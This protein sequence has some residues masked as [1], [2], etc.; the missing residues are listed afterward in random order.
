MI[1][2]II[3]R[4]SLINPKLFSSLTREDDF[5]SV[6]IKFSE[7]LIF[8]YSSEEDKKR[9]RTLNQV[10]SKKGE[11]NRKKVINGY[12]IE[13][14]RDLN[15]CLPIIISSMSYISYPIVPTLFLIIGN[16]LK[17][18]SK[19][20]I[21]MLFGNVENMKNGEEKLLSEMDSILYQQIRSNIPFDSDSEDSDYEEENDKSIESD[22]DEYRNEISEEESSLNDIY[23]EFFELNCEN[24]NLESLKN[25]SVLTRNQCE[26]IKYINDIQMPNYYFDNKFNDSNKIFGNIIRNKELNGYSNKLSHKSE[27]NEINNQYLSTDLCVACRKRRRSIVLWPCGCFCICNICRKVLAFEKYSKCPCTN[28]EVIGYSNIFIP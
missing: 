6:L 7:E 17:N 24:L 22:N 13:Y 23:K 25:S 3:D 5:Y 8:F 27:V 15:E 4:N 1:K 12:D 16:T 18:L 20:I 10:G 21:T 2:N 14:K 19:L 28:N 11:G 9:S 26:I